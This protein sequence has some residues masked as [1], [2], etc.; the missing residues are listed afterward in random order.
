MSFK[1]LPSKKKFA[2]ETI[3]QFT[4]TYLIICLVLPYAK[5]FLSTKK[6]HCEKISYSQKLLF[7]K[8]FSK[9]KFSK[10]WW[11]TVKK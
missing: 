1:K 8:K 4:N 7:E 10:F 6:N 11:E 9:N 3:R 5:K 2:G